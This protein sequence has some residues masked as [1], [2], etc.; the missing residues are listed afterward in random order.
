MS[1]RLA[2]SPANCRLAKLSEDEDWFPAARKTES[3]TSSSPYDGTRGI[4]SQ[5]GRRGISTSGMLCGV[6]SPRVW[7]MRSV[8][9]PLPPRNLISEGGEGDEDCEPSLRIS[10]VR[11]LVHMTG[12]V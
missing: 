6:V 8:E 12:G 7:P 9:I 2:S 5:F 4:K 11:S 10:L 3:S 1:R